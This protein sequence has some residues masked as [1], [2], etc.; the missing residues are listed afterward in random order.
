MENYP[1]MVALLGTV[2]GIGNTT[3]DKLSV[4]ERKPFGFECSKL[5]GATMLCSL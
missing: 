5:K 3:T 2:P 1:I 4:A